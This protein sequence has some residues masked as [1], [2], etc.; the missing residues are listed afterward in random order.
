MVR[1]F[2]I[3]TVYCVNEHGLEDEEMMWD[4]ANRTYKL[5][6]MTGSFLCVSKFVENGNN[7]CV[8]F[9]GPDL[10][11]VDILES[12]GNVV[13]DHIFWDKMFE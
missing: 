2:K 11:L 8:S 9:L 4:H 7:I 1:Q 3:G 6:N 10:N 13:G 5:V 12:H